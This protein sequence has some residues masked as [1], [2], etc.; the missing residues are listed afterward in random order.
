MKWENGDFWITD[1]QTALDADR[2]VSFLQTTYW[3]QGRPAVLIKQSFKNSVVLSLL[4]HDTQIGLVRI[5]SD[6]TM[7][8]WL[9]DVY[10]CPNYRGQGLGK[11][12]MKC[13]LE[14]PATNVQQNLLATR[15]A[16]GLYEQFGFKSKACMSR[17]TKIAF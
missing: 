13:T 1:D 17:L 6:Y 15:D 5:V 12:M 3:A 8:A 14:H 9:C 16:Q 4:K 11:W 10:I 2:A 7:F